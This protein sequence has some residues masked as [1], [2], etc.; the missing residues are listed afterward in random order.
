MPARTTWLVEYLAEAVLD[1]QAIEAKKER[2]GV[3]NVVDKLVALGPLLRPPHMKPLR[4]EPDLME[5][6]PRQGSSPVRP[7]YARFGD[8]FKIL[9]IAATKSEF[10]DALITARRRAARYSIRLGR[11]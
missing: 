9:A 7:I 11:S 6:R 2:T 8:T 4:G 10:D 5:L 3:L 1:L